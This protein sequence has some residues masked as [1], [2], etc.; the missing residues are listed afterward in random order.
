MSRP[1]THLLPAPRE[2]DARDV[3][4]QVEAEGGE[5]DGYRLALLAIRRGGGGVL[6]G[7]TVD[8]GMPQPRRPA[9]DGA[10]SDVSV[11]LPTP[12]SRHHVAMGRSLNVGTSPPQ[13]V[14]STTLRP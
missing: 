9:A 3:V 13:P 10:D 7:E 12:R 1:V 11:G 2:A 6:G 5:V 14:Q 4:L 8:V